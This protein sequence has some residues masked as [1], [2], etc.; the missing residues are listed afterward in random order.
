MLGRRLQ[1]HSSG[2]GAVVSVDVALSQ[3]EGAAQSNPTTTPAVGSAGVPGATIGS[4]TGAGAAPPGG[5]MPM[6]GTP[7]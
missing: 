1:F 4:P 2:G 6:I 3:S 7:R 5:L